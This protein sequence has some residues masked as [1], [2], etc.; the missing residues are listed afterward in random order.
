MVEL[1][2]PWE[3]S[4][5]VAFKREKGKYAE[6]AAACSQAGWRAFTFL[7]EVGSRGYTGASA[8]H[9][10]KTLGTRDAKPPGRMLKRQSRAA[11]GCG[12]ARRTKC[13]RSRDLRQQG[14]VPIIAPPPRDVGIMGRNISE[15][16]VP[17]DDPAAGAKALLEVCQAAMPSRQIYLAVLQ[18]ICLIIIN[19]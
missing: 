2:V 11:S 3:D 16:W 13:G 8:Q 5:E 6:L 9:L 7:V 12:F 18:I 10:F 4:M 1:T 14:D 15:G 19:A 17:A